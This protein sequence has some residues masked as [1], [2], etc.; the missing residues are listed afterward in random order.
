MEFR[1]FK[2]LSKRSAPDKMLP[3]KEFNIAKGPKYNG[4]QHGLT[5]MIYKFFYKKSASLAQSETLATRDKSASGRA[6]KDEI[7]SNKELAKELGKSIIKKFEK[8][9]ST[10]TFCRQYLGC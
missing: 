4:S 3:D 7:M 9:K 2:D 6:F 10:L 8:K 5:L 1:N